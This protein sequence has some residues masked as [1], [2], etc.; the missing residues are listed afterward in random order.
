MFFDHLAD[1]EFRT[2]VS[3]GHGVPACIELIV[4]RDVLAELGQDDFGRG[5]SQFQRELG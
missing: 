2:S 3:L 5:F 1:D 4:Y